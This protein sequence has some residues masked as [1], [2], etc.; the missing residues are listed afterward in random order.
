[1]NSLEL[2]QNWPSMAGAKPEAIYAS[3]AWAL[4]GR[5]GD[6]PVCLRRSDAVFRDVLGISIR[7]DEEEHFLGLGNREAF[8]DLQALWD[9]KNDLPDTLKLALVEKECGPLLQLIENAARKQ[10]S[11]VGVEPSSARKGSTGFE[12]V[13]VEDGNVLAV[14]DLDVTPSLVSAF[15]QLKYLDVNHDSIQSMTRDAWAVYASF[16]LSADELAGLAV[17]DCLLLPEA[18]NGAAKWQIS[19]PQDDFLTIAS[20]QPE[21]LTFLQFADEQLPPISAPSVLRIYRQ[22]R[23]IAQGRV[24]SLAEQPALVIEELF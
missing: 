19:L 7:L 17:G 14:F 5:W 10:L 24:E 2:L 6:R 23:A 9:V 4:T 3:P 18:T 8:P 15:G 16:A 20:A 12:V 1:M 21:K 22:G 11:I 13:D